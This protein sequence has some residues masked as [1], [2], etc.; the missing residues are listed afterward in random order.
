MSTSAGIE[1]NIIND[2]VNFKNPSEDNI[3]F[4]ETLFDTEETKELSNTQ[5]KNIVENSLQNGNGIGVGIY[6]SE[7]EP[8]IFNTINEP[9]DYVL[10]GAHAVTVTDVIEEGIVVSSWGEKFVI[11]YDELKKNRFRIS[12]LSHN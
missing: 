3:Q 4:N 1:V 10:D 5:I 8:T 2:Y 9:Y 11:T 6:A 12:V 7:E